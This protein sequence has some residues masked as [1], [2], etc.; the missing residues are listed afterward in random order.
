MSGTGGSYPTVEAGSEALGEASDAKAQSESFYLPGGD[1]ELRW[2]VDGQEGLMYLI[3]EFANLDTGS[4]GLGGGEFELETDFSNSD[5]RT[6]E[7]EAGEYVMHVASVNCQW[8]LE[9]WAYQ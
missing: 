4:L 1:V 3:V 8:N 5:S 9:V 7:K 6:F 2:T